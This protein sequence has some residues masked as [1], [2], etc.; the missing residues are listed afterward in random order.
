MRRLSVALCLLALACG[1]NSPTTPSDP[2][3]QTPT[4]TRII[5]I[6]GGPINFGG[7]EIGQSFVWN[8][9]IANDGNSSLTVSGVNGPGGQAAGLV[10]SVSAGTVIP[11]G[12]VI[13]WRITFAP[14]AIAQYNG[15]VTV[16]SDATSGTNTVAMTAFGRGPT[17][18][19]TGVGDDVFDVPFYVSRVRIT[20]NYNQNSSNFVVR[21]GGRLVVN[22]LLGTGWNQTAFAGNYLLESTGAGTVTL[23]SG[24]SWSITELR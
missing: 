13:P 9:Q 19:K 24:V 5:R 18:V 21:I 2:N 16:S 14:N 10:S 15:N 23:S 8:L 3:P 6:L 11:A 20:G 22:E 7:I 1:S 17:F 12:A 4:A